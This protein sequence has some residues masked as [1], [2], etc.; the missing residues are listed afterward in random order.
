V[1]ADVVVADPSPSHEKDNQE[2]EE[3]YEVCAWV[4]TQKV[5]EHPA[6][7]D[8]ANEVDFVDPLEHRHFVH[9]YRDLLSSAFQNFA[10]LLFFLDD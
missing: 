4:S 8:T 6:H 1:H 9:L 10:E 5:A 7:R 2:G 3:R